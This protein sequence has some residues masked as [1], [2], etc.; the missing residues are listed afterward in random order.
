MMPEMDGLELGRQ[1]HDIAG[2]ATPNMVMLSSSNQQLDSELLKQIGVARTVLKLIVRSDFLEIM[3]QVIAHGENP[4]KSS[5][6][7]FFSEEI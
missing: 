3:L 5:F 1:I 2:S 7:V 6:V 4:N